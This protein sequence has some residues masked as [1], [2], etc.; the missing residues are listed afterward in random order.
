MYQVGMK[1]YCQVIQRGC[2]GNRVY[3]EK[4]KIEMFRYRFWVESEES[5]PTYHA[6]IRR[7]GG[8]FRLEAN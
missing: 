8:R 1:N 5:V 7:S 4:K 6:K 3:R 2:W